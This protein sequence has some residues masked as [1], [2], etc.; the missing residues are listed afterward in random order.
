MN[1]EQLMS[2]LPIGV[3]VTAETGMIQYHNK[4]ALKMLK[5]PECKVTDESIM[6]V[7]PESNAIKSIKTNQPSISILKRNK[8]NPQIIYEYP[9]TMGGNPVGISLMFHSSYIEQLA[10]FVDKIRDLRQE[11]NL[12]MN[13]VGELVTITDA[14]GNIL[15]VNEKCER[16]L[17]VTRKDFIGKPLESLEK[18]KIVSTSSTKKVIEEG[19]KV[20][21][22]QTTKSGKRLL[23]SGHPIFNEEGTLTKVINISKDITEKSLITKELVELKNIIQQYE[24]ELH[25]KKRKSKP[26]IKSQRMKE[27]YDLVERIS[28]VDSTVLLLGESGVGKEVLARYLHHSST[29]RGDQPFVK[30]NCGAIP[31]ALIEGELFGYAQGQMMSPKQ[32]GTKIGLIE[33]AHQGTLFLDG[34]AE[35]PLHLQAKLLHVIQEK[36]ITPLGQAEPKEIDIR[37]IATTDRNL[38]EMVLENEFRSDLYYHLNIV[39]IRLPSLNER[40]EEIPFLIN[41]FLDRYNKKYS[42]HVTITEEVI[43][44]FIHY[45]W[46]GNVREL[47]NTIEML[48]VTVSTNEVTF[49]QLPEHISNKALLEIDFTEH[50]LK[51]AVDR[52]EKHLIENT[53]KNCL[54]LKEASMKLGIDASTITRKAKKYQLSV[55]GVK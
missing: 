40:K 38:E 24:S 54:T 46:K 36:K 18:E 5:L 23:V 29:I 13:L 22:T 20:T 31:E 52:Y 16:I 32:K 2:E 51:D 9:Q 44:A 47:Q 6:K 26:I 21:I 12:I 55:A 28:D 35:L 45:D 14:E 27:I 48:V 17:G 49:D 53:L 8:V 3:I 33:E 1:I 19:R 39:P 42:R 41:H 30:I 11:L 4:V 10:Y 34:I 50:S 43:S 7:L 15:K 25:S 37:I